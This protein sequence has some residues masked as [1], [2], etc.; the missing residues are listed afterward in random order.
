MQPRIVRADVVI[1]R[2]SSTG[3]TDVESLAILG[4][5]GRI[6]AVKVR[7]DN[8][9]P[10]TAATLYIA[11][12]ALTS[13]PDELDVFY[14][15]AS[16]ALTGSTTAADYQDALQTPAAYAVDAI[17]DLRVAAYVTTASG[18]SDL[19]VMVLAEVWD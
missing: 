5:Y 7:M 16:M 10:A 17:G 3:W 13:T 15:S 6:L 12:S 4:R 18:D 11:D 2:S 8:G 1:R 9:D 19:N 14:E